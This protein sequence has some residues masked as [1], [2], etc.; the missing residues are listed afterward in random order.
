MCEPVIEPIRLPTAKGYDRWAAVYEDDGNP[1][2]ALEQNHFER[3]MVNVRGL[4]ILDAGCG[5]GRHAVPLAQK[6]AIVTAIDFSHGML[7]K[8]R[9]KPGAD[10]VGFQQHDLQT[11]LPF[12]NN[13]FDRVISSLV[14]DHIADLAGFF[15]ELRRVCRPDGFVLI[16]VM[17]PA[18]MLRGVQACFTDPETGTLTLPDSQ[19]HLTS[20]YVTAI[21][22]AG[23]S[24]KQM[25][26]QSADEALAANCQRAR[27][28]VGWPM[29]LIF[30]LTP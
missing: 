15:R 21:L 7:T 4:R 28:Y 2:I 23:F 8:A 19:S 9:A 25:K 12:A 24:I 14:I 10:D 22:K 18:L 27:R 13:Q 5:T 16:T 29:L 3:L 6:G 26:E 30:E 11:P 1:L 17:H 20:D